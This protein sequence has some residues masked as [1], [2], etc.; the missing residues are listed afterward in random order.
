MLTRM[1]EP[2][3]SAPTPMARSTPERRNLP[4]EQADPALTA[5]AARSKLTTWVSLSTPGMPMQLVFGSLGE[6]L[7]C[8]TAAGARLRMRCS[9]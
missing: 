8:T 3:S 9:S 7:P 6:A 5:I 2:A 1:A 4:E